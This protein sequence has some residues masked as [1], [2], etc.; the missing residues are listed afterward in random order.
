METVSKN[1]NGKPGR[2][3][4]FPQELLDNSA[5]EYGQDM[6]MRPYFY[7]NRQKQNIV[8]AQRARNRLQEF[9]AEGSPE[10]FREERRHGQLYV[11]PLTPRGWLAYGAS[12][13]DVDAPQRILTELGRCLE[14]DEALFWRVVDWYAQYDWQGSR[15]A[16]VARDM[17]E[18]R[19]GQCTNLPGE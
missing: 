14:T 17:R 13:G 2:P 11:E 10:H 1:N 9:A 8:Y 7:S 15:A 6:D 16:D 12:I 5:H 18:L 19:L 3:R 4:A